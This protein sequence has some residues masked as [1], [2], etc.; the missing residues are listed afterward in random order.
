M[1]NKTHRYLFTFLL[2]SVMIFSEANCSG[3][4]LQLHTTLSD[5]TYLMFETIW[6][7]AELMNVSDDTVRIWGFEFPGGSRLKLFLTDEQGDT[8]PLRYQGFY[9]PWPGFILNPGETYF[10]A[11]A[12]SE[13]FWNY[14]VPSVSRHSLNATS[15][16]L[17]RYQVSAYYRRCYGSDTIR[18]STINFK[19]VEPT[20]P[21][22]Q[23]LELFLEI[24]KSWMGSDHDKANQM[25]SKLKATYPKSV[26]LERAYLRVDREELFEKCPDSGYLLNR[27]N[28]AVEKISGEQEKRKFL[29]GIIQKH[30][31]TR[32]AR[33]AEQKLRRL[34]RGELPNVQ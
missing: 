4:Q 26:Y 3:Q 31:G 12:L 11:F 6:L 30:A 22:Q 17:G 21:E 19:V 23:A 2:A 13:I 5:T 29:E 33:F 28:T 7:D 16:A 8:L 27:L 10:E 24:Y 32:S 9:G 15:L 25:L 20:G 34:E 14:D 18:T 1:S